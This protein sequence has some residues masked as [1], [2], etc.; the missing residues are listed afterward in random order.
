MRKLTTKE[1]PCPK[2]GTQLRLILCARCYGTGKSG[3]RECRSCGG[4]GITTECPNVGSHR[5][6]SWP[7]KV[8]FPRAAF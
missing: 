5:L 2:C 4:T 1:G 6:W 3:E 8:R 7:A